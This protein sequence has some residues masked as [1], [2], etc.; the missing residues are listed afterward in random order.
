MFC[1]FLHFRVFLVH[2]NRGC[3]T[4]FVITVRAKFL[5]VNLHGCCFLPH[6]RVKGTVLCAGV[7]ATASYLL[8]PIS[9]CCCVHNCHECFP[10]D[11][12]YYVRVLGHPWS[13]CFPP[14]HEYG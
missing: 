6:C 14:L 7:P 1:M 13:V 12:I 4:L 2:E 9:A 11:W 8:P 3:C 5:H 10:S